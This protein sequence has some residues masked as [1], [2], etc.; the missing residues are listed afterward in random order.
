MNLSSEYSESLT[1]VFRDLQGHI[2]YLDLGTPS[3]LFLSLYL[4][5]FS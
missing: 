5:P 2:L 4:V 3:F 1:G